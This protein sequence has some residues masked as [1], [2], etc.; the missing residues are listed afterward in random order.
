MKI[1]DILNYELQTF[2]LEFR[3]GVHICFYGLVIFGH[4]LLML[5]RHKRHHALK[6]GFLDHLVWSFSYE[7][8]KLQVFQGSNVSRNFDGVVHVFKF[9]AEVNGVF[10]FEEA[11]TIVLNFYFD[12]ET[13]CMD[14]GLFFLISK[15]MML[16]FFNTIFFVPEVSEVRPI[17]PLLSLAFPQ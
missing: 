9:F 3:I 10:S 17:Q 1:S 12:I 5:L 16:I 14:F 4:L 13:S 2:R 6:I 15:S 8:V 11:V 7:F